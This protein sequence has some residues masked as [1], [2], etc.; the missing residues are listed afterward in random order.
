MRAEVALARHVDSWRGS[1]NFRQQLVGVHCHPTEGAKSEQQQRS[2]SV[3]T[4]NYSQAGVA[5]LFG[6]GRASPLRGR[7]QGA[8]TTDYLERVATASD[9]RLES[10]N[11][12]LRALSSHVRGAIGTSR[13]R[14]LARSCMSLLTETCLVCNQ[15]ST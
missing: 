15:M 9:E 6:P 2:G 4:M 5:G 11:R 13:P 3:D 7:P 12:A 1:P 14:R 10:C 8:N